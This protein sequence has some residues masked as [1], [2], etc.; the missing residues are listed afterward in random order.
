MRITYALVLGAHFVLPI[1]ITEAVVKEA[2]VKKDYL[3]C[4]PERQFK[5][6]ERLRMAGDAR[7]LRE[8]TVGALLSRT[9]ISLRTGTSVFILGGG[10]SPN[11][12]RIKPKGSFRTFFTSEIAFEEPVDSKK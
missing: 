12:I 10:K 7:A 11:V 2:I 8:F 5:L 6:A 9:C 1:Q 4:S 3:A